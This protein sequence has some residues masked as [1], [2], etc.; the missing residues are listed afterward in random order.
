MMTAPS[1]KERFL[2]ITSL[3]TTQVFFGVLVVI[4]GRFLP[5]WKRLD[6]WA[7]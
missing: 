1:T 3:L 7:V 6:S 4:R 2:R 5:I